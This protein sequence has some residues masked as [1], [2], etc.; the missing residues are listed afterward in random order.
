MLMGIRIQSFDEARLR[1]HTRL[2]ARNGIDPTGKWLFRIGSGRTIFNPGAPGMPLDS[3][4][5]T[6][7]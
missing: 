2:L 5:V 3:K 7:L 4:A 6:R 1:R